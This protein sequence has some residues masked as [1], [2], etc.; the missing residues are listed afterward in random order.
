L[1][2]FSIKGQT[3]DVVSCINTAWL[4][5]K[6]ERVRTG[7]ILEMRITFLA[8]LPDG[9]HQVQIGISDSKLT[10]FHDLVED[11]V[12]FSVQGSRCRVGTA[13]LQGEMR[14]RLLDRSD[15]QETA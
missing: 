10:R 11:V 15:L 2:G 14:Y 7:Q 12:Q 5:E 9:P 4:G 3:G 1:F 6:T 13:D 8:A